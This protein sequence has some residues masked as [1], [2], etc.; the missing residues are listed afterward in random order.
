ME[1]YKLGNIG[2]IIIRTYNPIDGIYPTKYD[3]QPY[4]FLKDK[5]FAINFDNNTSDIKRRTVNELATSWGTIDSIEINDVELNSKILNL[6][7]QPNESKI[8]S[9]AENYD[10][11]DEGMIYLTR[12]NNQTI[13][14][15]FIYND[16]GD[17]ETALDELNSDELQVERPNSN[18]FIIYNFE[19]RNAFNFS[20]NQK[21]YFTLDI[22][23]IMNEDEES[24]PCH[25]HIDK[26]QLRL[27]QRMTF[28][29]SSNTIDLIF[30]VVGHTDNYICLE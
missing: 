25:I 23:T 9:R 15:I 17:L 3:N 21:Y 26:C 28:K 7:Y 11:D 1:N 20:S 16:D 27:D 12:P 10:S 30:K 19:G 18:Y 4:T 22:T 5:E 2:Q 24:Q 6:V 13:Y 29:Q 14:Q 8:C